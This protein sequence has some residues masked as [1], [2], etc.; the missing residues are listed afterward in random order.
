MYI[1]GVLH[2]YLFINLGDPTWKN[3]DWPQNYQGYDVIKQALLSWEMQ[4]HATMWDMEIKGLPIQEG[5][6]LGKHYPVRWFAMGNLIIRSPQI[7][8]LGFVR[9]PAF[10]AINLI[11]LYT[12]VFMCMCPNK[13]VLFVSNKN[14][15]FVFKKKFSEFF[16]AQPWWYFL[17][18]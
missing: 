3:F 2:W 5:T 11:F 6:Q 14:T 10:M 18:I 7:I 9:I 4:Y 15:V 13:N 8:L 12:I 1:I 16:V 17:F